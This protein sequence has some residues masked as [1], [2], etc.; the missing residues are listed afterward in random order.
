M[1][2]LKRNLIFRFF[3]ND[4]IIFNY[5]GFINI[6]TL[7]LVLILRIFYCILINNEILLIWNWLSINRVN[8]Y[9]IILGMT[10]L[11]LKVFLWE[12]TILI[13]VILGLLIFIFYFSVM[14]YI[15][16]KLLTLILNFLGNIFL[17]KI[18]TN[19]HIINESL[20]RKHVWAKILWHKILF[21]FHIISIVKIICDGLLQ[22]IGLL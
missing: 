9:I 13:L 6:L 1:L 4:C 20:R 21:N 10:I 19:M 12:L 2:G 15:V 5:N 11:L 18:C 14:A 7:K 17:L 8:V 3:C 22:Q 16:L